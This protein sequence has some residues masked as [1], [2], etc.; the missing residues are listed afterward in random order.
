M[1]EIRLDAQK[2]LESYQRPFSDRADSIGEVPV[3]ATSGSSLDTGVW[4]SILTT[5]SWI[6]VVTNVHNLYIAQH[7][8]TLD[9]GFRHRHHFLLHPKAC[10]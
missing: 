10:V 6:A 7:V 5:V 8:L 4:Q 1:F 2:F 9:A 3:M